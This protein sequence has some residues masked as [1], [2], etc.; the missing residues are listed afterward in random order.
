MPGM[1]K[2]IFL[3][4]VGGERERESGSVS[5]KRTGG[6]N[7]KKKKKKNIPTHAIASASATLALSLVNSHGR[8]APPLQ[9]Q[10]GTTRA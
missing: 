3:F 5:C 7:G 4:E 10:P 6:S 2:L 1:W 9:V 8:G